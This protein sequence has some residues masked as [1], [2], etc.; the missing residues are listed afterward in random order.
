MAGRVRVLSPGL[1]VGVSRIPPSAAPS[2]SDVYVIHVGSEDY[3]DEKTRTQL[4]RQF[5]VPVQGSGDGLFVRVAAGTEDEYDG[6]ITGVL[7][8][9]EHPDYGTRNKGYGHFSVVTG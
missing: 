7:E 6:S 9:R 5:W 2:G 3:Y 8:L 4:S 1:P